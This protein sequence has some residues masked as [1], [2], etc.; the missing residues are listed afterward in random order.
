[1]VK[2]WQ[3]NISTQQTGMTD[4]YRPSEH[5]TNKSGKNSKN[6]GLEAC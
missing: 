2:H 5:E 1:M 3:E 6:L 4:H